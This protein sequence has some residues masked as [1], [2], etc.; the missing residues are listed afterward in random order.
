VIS[1]HKELVDE[2]A[3]MPNTISHPFA[4]FVSYSTLLQ[5]STTDKEIKTKEQLA[6]DFVEQ[7]MCILSISTTYSSNDG[8][9]QLSHPAK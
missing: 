4:E 3:W 5:K 8:G 2:G 9:S 6:K 7:S 1:N